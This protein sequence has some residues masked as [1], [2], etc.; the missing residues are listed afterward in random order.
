VYR[1]YF[2][3]PESCQFHIVDERWADTGNVIDIPNCPPTTTSSTM[4]STTTTV[5]TTIST[6]TTIPTTTIETTVPTTIPPCDEVTLE[7]SDKICPKTGVT[8]TAHAANAEGK[9]VYFKTGSCSGETIGVCGVHNGVCNK[10]VGFSTLGT[11]NVFACVDKNNDGDF[12]D[13][14]EQD[15]K[16]VN[17][18]CN[19][20]LMQ[21]DCINSDVCGWCPECAGVCN[22]DVNPWYKNI[23]L[24]PGESC[25]HQ[26]EAGYC[27]VATCGTTWG[28]KTEVYRCRLCAYPSFVCP[29]QYSSCELYKMEEGYAVINPILVATCNSGQVCEYEAKGYF[30][31]VGYGIV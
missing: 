16:T 20:C 8:L 23:C 12:T 27:D 13:A 18:D 21:S 31:H 4:T 2:C 1:D 17:V 5:E 19:N 29:S 14:C 3:S 24:N 25:T 15:N 10:P 11:F 26:C 28:N 9:V 7:L 30:N 22:H 6:T